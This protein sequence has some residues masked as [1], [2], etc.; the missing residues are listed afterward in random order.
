MSDEGQEIIEPQPQP[1]VD[2]L[3][4]KRRAL[5]NAR[6]AKTRKRAERAA[7]PRTHATTPSPGPA[8]RAEHPREATLGPETIT[9]RRRG[10]RMDG[11]LDVPVH[12]KKSGWDYQWITLRV[13]GQPV[14][15]S[16]LRDWY[17]GGWRPVLARDIPELADVGADPMSPI[18]SKAMR[19]VTRPMS[20]TIEARQE[21]LNAALEQQRDRMMA[22]ASGK[23]VVRGE[24]GIPTNQRGIR[25]V[26]VQLEIVGE[27][28][29]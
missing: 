1:A 19:L 22:A 15:G 10:E 9:R 25:A 29:S 13:L 8:G 5:E 16:D 23:S 18:E 26:P 4:Q 27:V 12:R 2:R 21:D 7:T 28:G 20:L 6:A 14:D 24:E 3:A 11:G 17:E